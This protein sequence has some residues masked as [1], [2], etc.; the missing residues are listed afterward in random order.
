VG[1]NQEMR[2]MFTIYVLLT[3]AGLVV[4]IA[5]GLAHS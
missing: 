4:Y 1:Q 3:V 5:I 2:T